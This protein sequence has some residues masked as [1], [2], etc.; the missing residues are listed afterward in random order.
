MGSLRQNYIFSLNMPMIL[1]SKSYNQC[2]LPVVTYGCE[3]WEITKRIK[4]KLEVHLKVMERRSL[5][6]FLVDHKTNTR[7]RDNTKDLIIGVLKWQWAGHLARYTENWSRCIT[8]WIHSLQRREEERGEKF[9]LVK[10]FS[11]WY[12]IFLVNI[13]HFL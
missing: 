12:L 4:N 11:F 5:E 9:F 8:R 1:K 3:I 10:Q 2:I 7:I 6:I 13:T